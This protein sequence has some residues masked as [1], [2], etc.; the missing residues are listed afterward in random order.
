MPKKQKLSKLSDADDAAL[1]KL[2]KKERKQAVDGVPDQSD[3]DNLDRLFSVYD[4]Y[5]RGDLT[6]CINEIKVQRALNNRAL[7]EPN[8]DSAEYLTF[9]MPTPLL[10]FMEKYYPTIWTN[11]EHLR[12]FLKKFPAFRT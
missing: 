9:K 2:S 1:A 10:E 7:T 5:T 3:V 8:I 12:W 11:K 4:Y 6:K